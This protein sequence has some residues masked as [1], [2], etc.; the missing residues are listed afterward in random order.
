MARPN[1]T[2]MPKTGVFNL[3]EL[4]GGGAIRLALLFGSAAVAMTIVLMPV[5]QTQITRTAAVD[6]VD[7]IA[8]GSTGSSADRAKNQLKQVYTIR[9]SVLQQDGNLC[10][11]GETGLRTGDC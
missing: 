6:S 7:M 11:I 10:I 5:A 8:T 1:D 2:D 4:A 3:I 9:R